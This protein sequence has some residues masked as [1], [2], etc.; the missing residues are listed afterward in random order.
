MM[1]SGMEVH[2]SPYQGTCQEGQKIAEDFC[3]EVTC[4]YLQLISDTQSVL[5]AL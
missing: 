3:E 4:Y 1:N 5:L 2:N